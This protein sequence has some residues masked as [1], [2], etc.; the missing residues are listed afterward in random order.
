MLAPERRV[1]KCVHQLKL[2]ALILISPDSCCLPWKQI[3]R[4]NRF[5][6]AYDRLLL[7]IRLLISAAPVR[8]IFI[9]PTLLNLHL[10]TWRLGSERNEASLVEILYHRE[11]IRLVRVI[12]ER[13]RELPLSGTIGLT[14]WRYDFTSAAHSAGLWNRAIRRQ[15]SSSSPRVASIESR[16]SCDKQR[17]L[18]LLCLSVPYL[19]IWKGISPLSIK[20]DANFF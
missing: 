13:E 11:I 20:T 1:E 17:A 2:D 8:T 7:S 14:L 4:R 6:R 5:G 9:L 16:E 15:T 3:L 10:F 19:I 12:S 18:K